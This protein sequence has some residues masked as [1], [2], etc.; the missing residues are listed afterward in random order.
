MGVTW[1]EQLFLNLAQAV[2]LFVLLAF[3]AGR[4]GIL[5]RFFSQSLKWKERATL[6][7]LAGL[8]GIIGTYWG[9]PVQGAIANT[10]V[11]GPMVAGLFG[12]PLTGMA[13]GLIAGMHRYTL[14]GFTALACGISTAAE[15]LLAGLVHLYQ[16][17]RGRQVTWQAAFLATVAAEMLQM[18][19]ILLLARPWSEAVHLVEQIALPMTLMNAVGV[20]LVVGIIRD[21]RQQQ[22]RIAALQAQTVLEIAS[23][24]LPHLREGLTK[25]SARATCEI[26]MERSD[27][28]A[29]SITDREII[30]AYVGMGS[31]HH[32]AGL[33]P[34][35]QAT[36]DVLAGGRERV[37]ESTEDLGCAVPGCP[38]SVGVAVP[39]R[40]GDQVVGTL[41]LYQKGNGPVQQVTLEL[42]GGL[43]HLLS[44]QIELS[45]A[46]AM[47]QLVVQA[48]LRALH[49]QI[50]PH[51]LFNALGTIGALCRRDPEK[52]RELLVMLSQYLR[53]S[54]RAGNELV[55]LGEELG[56]VE[57]YLA[58]EQARFGE[59]L[60]TVIEVDKEVLDLQVP[61][62]SIQPLVENSVRHGIMPRVRG[63]TVTITG[64]RE[65]D[66][67]VL[68][69]SDDGVGMNIP[70][71]RSEN[72][73]GVGLGNVRNRLRYLY[74]AG[75][76]MDV[77]SGPDTGTTVRLRLPLHPQ[78][79]QEI[80]VQ[81]RDLLSLSGR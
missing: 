69:V 76:L 71:R 70:A 59:R 50:N 25:S 6:A 26:I 19:I 81:G 45:R 16:T 46:H 32:R 57:A 44:S 15:G 42:G 66:R 17:R 47:S 40:V 75:E 22:D 53:S 34:Q 21:A 10:R 62:L 11:F 56:F 64:R 13:A 38:L 20:G 12:G 74:G 7:V 43:G 5:A 65:G 72:G 63:G 28:G 36:W 54:I 52:A 4:V 33:R 77:T 35:T 55:T 3:V 67:L 29:V 1:L 41:H 68:T 51:F 79:L 37:V 18:A 73:N 80:E 8:L 39:L 61:I 2:S 60:C 30:L 24:T 23:K 9:V 31:D 78:P 27:M 14:G 49:A 58:I 48:E